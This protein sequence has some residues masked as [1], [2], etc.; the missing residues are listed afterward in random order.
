MS[1]PSSSSSDASAGRN[2]R[3]R[4][5]WVVG[6]LAAALAGL[7][8]CAVIAATA[9]YFLVRQDSVSNRVEAP[10]PAVADQDEALIEPS[11]QAVPANE[12]LNRIA[13]VDPDGRLGTV[14][15]DGSDLR[16]L[17]GPGVRFQFPAW[18]PNGSGIAAIGSDEQQASVYV[19][20]EG[21]QT[22]DETLEPLYQS[23]D[24]APFYLYWSPDSQQVSFLANDRGSIA[25][26]LVPADGSEVSRV[27]ARGQPFYWDWTSGGDQLLIHTGGVGDNARLGFIDI[28][29][30]PVG[31]EYSTP[32]LFQAPGISPSGRFLAFA[33]I[34]GEE[35]HVVAQDSQGTQRT[36][37][38]HQGI[39]AMTW[40]PQADRLAFI[41]P[42][43][44]APAF[45]GPLRMLD[46]ATG[47]VQTLTNDVVLAFFWSPDGQS[48]AY[49]TLDSA[50]DSS[51]A[52]V[53][54]VASATKGTGFQPVA[55]HGQRQARLRLSVVDVD[56]GERR[57]LTMFQSTRL[58]VSQ[59]LPYF[60]QYALSHRIWSPDST[61]LVMPMVGLDGEE[62]IHVVPVDGGAPREVASGSIG[63]WSQ[64]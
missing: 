2:G 11:E 25:L 40:S 1:E 45:F 52:Q 4:S 10:A 59:F 38:P 41:S 17:T 20:A 54:G 42:Q 49:L 22:A 21:A 9:A 64:Q 44:Q 14:S 39:A 47:E 46:A 51:G 27:L 28:L 63:F 19:V 12:S 7:M 18:A 61:A 36:E 23:S 58:F 6:G 37:V 31:S 43:V 48:I 24:R 60:D 34:E 16:L 5:L 8:M 26:H 30:D 32:G 33:A 29:G 55:N 15:P 62:R 13:F 50:S 35:F 57:L 3:N 56:S 53:P